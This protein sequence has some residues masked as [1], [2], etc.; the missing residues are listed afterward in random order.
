MFKS[1]QVPSTGAKA[2]RGIGDG[3]GL[4]AVGWGRI[5]IG[6]WWGGV[7]WVG[8]GE[9]GGAP[10]QIKIVNYIRYKS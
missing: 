7:G 9:V 8:W 4:G 1:R 3:L 2:L 5:G 6:L 10:L